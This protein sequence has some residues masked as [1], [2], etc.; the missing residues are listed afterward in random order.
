MGTWPKPDNDVSKAL[1]AESDRGCVLVAAAF[2]DEQIKKLLRLWFTTDRKAS[3]WLID[4]VV[5]GKS[6]TEPFG[7]AVWCLKTAAH[8]G[9]ITDEPMRKAIKQLNDRRNDFAHLAHRGT[10]LK[11]DVGSIRQ[12]LQLHAQTIN[13]WI[14]VVQ[15]I[16]TDRVLSD[17]RIEFTAVAVVLW[18]EIWKL[19]NAAVAPIAEEL[20]E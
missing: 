18:C 7:T 11:E 15:K 16:K 14:V 12:H 1:L 5:E 6:S 17:E 20:A 2:L 10:I 9:L 3:E 13:E 4:K 19:I 8:L